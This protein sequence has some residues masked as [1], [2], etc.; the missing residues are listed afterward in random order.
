[1]SILEEVTGIAAAT[2]LAA[3]SV[4]G[5]P[6]ITQMSSDALQAV[7]SD[8]VA[9]YI[10]TLDNVGQW[11]GTAD[12]MVAI[13]MD[14]AADAIRIDKEF[15]ESLWYRSQIPMKKEHQKLLW[16]YCKE[17]KLD[18]IDML[19]LI[20]LESNFDEKCKS[21]NG[22][23]Q[24]YFQISKV[25]WASLSETLNTPNTPL[26]GAVNINWGTRMYSWILMD[27]RVKDL[28]GKEQRD[29][30]LSIYQRGSAGYN[31]SGL[32]KTYLKV[33]YNRREQIL[34][35]FQDE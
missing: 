31:K 7:T 12:D 16:E 6:S 22:R 32:S 26:D 20:S 11:D 5:N 8:E 19:T 35:Y 15:D 33:F 23:Y 9:A 2:F 18:Y 29:V 28:E 21:T 13:C 14:A 4:L 27:E 17:R 24:G 3:S 34:S 10:Q 30:A 25:H 1:M